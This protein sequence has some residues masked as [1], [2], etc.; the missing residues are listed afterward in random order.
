MSACC[1]SRLEVSGSWRPFHG[2]YGDSPLD[3]KAAYVLGVPCQ[4]VKMGYCESSELL[5]CKP[6][7]VF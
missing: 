7:G 3:V 6:A 2:I 5:S 4:C 1:R